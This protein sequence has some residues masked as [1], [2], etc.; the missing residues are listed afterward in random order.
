[1]WGRRVGYTALKENIQLPPPSVPLSECNAVGWEVLVRGRGVAFP[2]Y[3]APG[4]QCTVAPL[5]HIGWE[6][7]DGQLEDETLHTRWFMDTSS[8]CPF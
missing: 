3:Y 7:P 1:M 8:L 6:K 4:R 5:A 2:R